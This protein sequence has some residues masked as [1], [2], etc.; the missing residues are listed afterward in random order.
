M[1]PLRH[2][3]AIRGDVPGLLC[4]GTMLRDVT[5]LAPDGFRV[6]VDEATVISPSPGW[7]TVGCCYGVSAVE[8]IGVLDWRQPGTLYAAL[9]WL[10]D[11]G[12]P[13]LWML[14]S[15]H[16]GKVEPWDGLTA[17]EVSA[18]LVSASVARVAEGG[19]PVGDLFAG[20]FDNGGTH[21]RRSVRY[22][23]ARHEAII[24]CAYGGR[25][26]WSGYGWDILG[27]YHPCGVE[28]GDAGMAAADA[29]A[30]TDGVALL[31]PGGVA[32]RAPGAA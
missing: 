20:W 13:C 11:R 21:E 28:T 18:I 15:S 12:H 1:T 2:P 14:P 22:D 16:G 32:V 23:H 9:H 19:K 3:I 17:W 5:V 10:A 24:L 6:L 7:V 27:E 26:L 4:Q 31:V 25:R 8:R 29:A 30:L